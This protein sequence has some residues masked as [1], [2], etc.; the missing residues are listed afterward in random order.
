MGLN[1]AKLS[2]VIDHIVW[3]SDFDYGITEQ[4]VDAIVPINS[5]GINDV[6]EI[7]TDQAIRMVNCC[8]GDMSAIVET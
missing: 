2:F 5:V 4:H 6:P 8:D 1:W 3:G 7:Q